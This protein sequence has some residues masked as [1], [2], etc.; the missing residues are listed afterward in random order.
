MPRPILISGLGIAGPATAFWL[1]RKGLPVEI[2]EKA[3]R[4]RTGGYAVD[5]WGIGYDAVERMG[6]IEELRANG[7]RFGEAREVNDR[8]KRISGINFSTLG[9][10]LG[11][12]FATI[13]RGDLGEI[14]YRAVDNVPVRFGDSIAALEERDD[15]VSVAFESGATSNYSLVIG[16]DGLHSRVRELTFGS[17]GIMPLGYRVASF[18]ADGYPHRTEDAY[19]SHTEP[20]RQ[21]ARYALREGKTAFLL[22]WRDDNKL[23][24]HVLSEQKQA[25]LRAYQGMG[26]EWP[27][28][29]KWLDRTDEL[30]FDLV[31]QTRFER[32]SKGRV[33]LIGD[34]AVCP[35]LVVGEGSAMA[36][37]AA[38]ILVSKL[39]AEAT[40]E[41]AFASYERCVREPFE[42]I[43]RGALTYAGAFA[44]KTRLG[45]W[46][47]NRVL[48]LMNAPLIGPIMSRRA[49]ISR[50]EWPS[51]ALSVAVD[52]VGEQANT[53]LR[54]R[55]GW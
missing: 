20:G 54:R 50:F 24:I 26:W 27:E 10:A 52:S 23:P 33:V 11:D 15:A 55:Q 5:I 1:N 4:L 21:L 19:I 14:L 16:A 8:G 38:N 6:L 44:P 9:D 49:F 43:Q 34:A 45:L 17:V 37:T 7:Y 22:V 46:F 48:D 47:R 39:L 40:H 41:Q 12:R 30:Y 29:R 51:D 35:S 25:V 28:V 13:L 53:S 31:A 18:V 32:W 3:P 36:M 2:V 42:R